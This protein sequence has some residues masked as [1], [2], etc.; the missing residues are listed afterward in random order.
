[1]CFL[2]CL[3]IYNGIALLQ[4]RIPYR[5][6]NYELRYDKSAHTIRYQLQP[7]MVPHLL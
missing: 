2:Y 3:Y 1:M 7:Y 4:F 6:Y 5:K